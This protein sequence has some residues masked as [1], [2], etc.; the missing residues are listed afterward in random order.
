VVYTRF[1]LRDENAVVGQ[2]GPRNRLNVSRSSALS[3]AQTMNANVEIAVVTRSGDNGKDGKKKRKRC[4]SCKRRASIPWLRPSAIRCLKRVSMPD[5][6][7]GKWRQRSFFWPHHRMPLRVVRWCRHTARYSSRR[8]SPR[9]DA[10]VSVDTIVQ[11]FGFFPRGVIQVLFDS[12]PI[13]RPV[14]AWK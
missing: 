6:R 7:S 12:N 3:G 10:K 2:F 9:T 8:R 4:S 5:L 1:S 14:G 13:Q 11:F